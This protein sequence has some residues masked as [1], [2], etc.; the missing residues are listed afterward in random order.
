MV[1]NVDQRIEI[2]ST[3]NPVGS[4]A[5]ALGMGQAFIGIADDAT[6]AS[7]NPAGLIQ[8]ERPEIS[9]VGGHTLRTDDISY[10]AFQESSN[11][12]DFTR[13]ELNYLSAAYPFHLFH[14]NMIV[15]LNYQ[16]MYNF[17]KKAEISY[18]DANERYSESN[19][20]R[21][22][23]TG[24]L[25]TVSPA[26]AVE[27]T[28]ELSLGFTLNFWDNP[29][30]R[31][32]WQMDNTIKRVN[33]RSGRTYTMF[34][35]YSDTYQFKGF[36]FHTGLLWAINSTVTVGAVFRSPFKADLDHTYTID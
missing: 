2:G 4:G 8:L 30:S 22:R 18:Q 26:F 9:V 19:V 33:S 11:K 21:Y 1:M 3:P 23:Q 28:P 14:K 29:F 13:T 10:D 6:A 25:Y 16:H 27:I 35:H 32:Q 17:N 34:E 15:S 36:N 5:R 24:D 20:I 7:W 31:N 12:T